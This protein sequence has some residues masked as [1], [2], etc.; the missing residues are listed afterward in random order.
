M[1]DTFFCIAF[2]FILLFNFMFSSFAL[3][4]HEIIESTF[5]LYMDRPECL[6]P[7]VEETVSLSQIQTVEDGEKRLYFWTKIRVDEDKNIM[8]VWSAEGRIDRWAERVHIAWS[9]KLR[10]LASEVIGQA[11]DFLRIM[12]NSNP[13]LDN[14]Q[15][16]MLPINR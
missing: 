13:S 11:K 6:I 12:Y 8:H 10:N 2:F 14:V 7:C 15:G 1:K 3:A 5:C 4:Q 16:V 9:D